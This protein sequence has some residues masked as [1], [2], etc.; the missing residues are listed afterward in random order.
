MKRILIVLLGCLI[1]F[2]FVDDVQKR[3][4]RN[5]AYDI[6][7]FITKKTINNYNS[8]KMY[9]WFKSGKI[10]QSMSSSGGFLLHNGYTKYY[11]DNQLAEQGTFVHGLKNGEWKAWYHNGQLKTKTYWDNGYKQWGYTSFDSLGKIT[12]KGQYRKNIKIGKWINYTTKD[13]LYYKDNEALE[14]RPV[15][16]VKRLLTKKDSLVK[17]QRKEERIRKRKTDSLKRVKLKQERL[18]KRRNDS[19]LKA[20]NKI[21]KIRQKKIDSINKSKQAKKSLLKQKNK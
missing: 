19:I 12:L 16:L 7:C 20:Q 17:I 13:T 18:I 9:Y 10:H 6:E 4:I 1:C 8:K 3:V 15:G 21:E 11:K 2:S 5:K 14:E